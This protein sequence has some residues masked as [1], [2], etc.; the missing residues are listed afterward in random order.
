MTNLMGL[1]L[2]SP[3]RVYLYLG[4]AVL[5]VAG[6]L[7]L[8][9]ILPPP[10]KAGQEGITVVDKGSREI[11]GATP[12]PVGGPF[13]LVS[14]EGKLLSN[15]DFRGKNMYIFFGYTHCPDVCPLT[16]NNVSRGLALLG[17][18]ANKIQPIFI[19]LDPLRDTPD[20]LKDYLQH[21]D[22]RF[23]GLTGTTKQVAVAQRSYRIF[24]Q[25]RDEDPKDPTDYLLD[26][27]SISYMMGPKG[28]FKTFFSNG[29]TPEQFA[30]KMKEH[31]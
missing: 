5:I 7:I 31:L 13:T 26:H 30:A 17:E 29:S 23:I 2:M 9:V 28:E 10:E 11:K 22:K 20:V 12:P 6:G 21:F 3:R 27:T 25:K 14:H 1:Q 8:R 24:V 4:I 18:D 19:S 16:L 15:A